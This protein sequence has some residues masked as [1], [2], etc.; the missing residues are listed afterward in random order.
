MASLKKAK[1]GFTLVEMLV[2]LVVLSLTI[3]VSSQAY[4]QYVVSSERFLKKYRDELTQLQQDEL[5]RER[6]SSARLY[7][8]NSSSLMGLNK[9]SPFMIG[10]NHSWAG[11]T[12]PSIQ[13]ASYAA[14]FLLRLQGE[15]LYY[16]ESLIKDSLPESNKLPTDICEFS[17]LVRENVDDVSFRYFG[18]K[19]YSTLV[20]Y[21][22]S[23]LTGLDISSIKKRWFDKYLGVETQL[24][25]QWV[26]LTINYENSSEAWMIET[27]N[28][29]P[30]IMYNAYSSSSE[31]N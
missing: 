26:E 22:Q 13:D 11:V 28:Q 18:W 29:D 27:Q 24:M 15:K 31:L 30:L 25:P 19:D 16:C 20:T 9:P 1:Q 6:L 12:F 10:K 5:V 2:A 14:V 17:I 4:S 21:R 3:A 7:M 8:A 23:P